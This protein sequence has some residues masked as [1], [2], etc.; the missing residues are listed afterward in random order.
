MQGDE[1]IG[2][3]VSRDLTGT[4][5][6]RAAL[7][8]GIGGG[9]LYGQGDEAQRARDERGGINPASRDRTL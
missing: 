5:R 2:V 9:G 8:R 6:E 3:L 7:G 4:P 1:G